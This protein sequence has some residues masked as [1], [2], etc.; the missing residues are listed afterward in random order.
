MMFVVVQGIIMSSDNKT[1]FICRA[2]DCTIPFVNH[3]GRRNHETTKHQDICDQLKG[4]K[5]EVLFFRNKTLRDQARVEI[6][7][8]LKKTKRKI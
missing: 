7:D 8:D 1:L 5:G 4:K 3:A 6:R 2:P